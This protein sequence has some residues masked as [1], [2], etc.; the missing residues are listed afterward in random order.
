MADETLGFYGARRLD[1][2]WHRAGGRGSCGS[3]APG[4]AT[5]GLRRWRASLEAIRC[6]VWRP[7]GGSLP[8]KDLVTI[9]IWVLVLILTR[10]VAAWLSL[11]RPL[12]FFEQTMPAWPP[13][14]PF[15]L[16]LERVLVAPWA[17]WDAHW[18]AR[19]VAQGY[20]AG[21]GTT[22]FYPLYPL[23]AMPL[24]WLGLSPIVALMLVSLGASLGVILMFE[25]MA[26]WEMNSIRAREVTLAFMLFPVAFVLSAPYAEALFLLWAI[27]SVSAARQGRWGRAGLAAALAAL[28]RPQGLFLLLPLGALLWRTRS[29]IRPFGSL[30]LPILALAGWSVYRITVIEGF[31]LPG[32]GLNVYVY[33]LL[34]SPHANQVVPSQAFLW[35][36]EALGRALGKFL[37]GPDVDLTVN[38]VLAA[39]FL[40]LTARA[41]RWMN[42]GERLYTMAVVMS[43]FSYHTGPVHPYM[44]LPRHLW[45]AFPVFLAF[46]RSRS[47]LTRVIPAVQIPAFFFMIILYVLEAWVP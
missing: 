22:Q 14:A 6:R 19:I 25:R 28:T 18:Y 4:R 43:A 10:L 7:P 13:T 3:G 40:V 45:I 37:Q 47:A 20:Q 39:W 31:H 38:L 27:V 9:A 1:C 41:W 33:S 2:S 36:W 16:W 23:L 8:W 29:T 32:K 11:L 15:S 17:R 34:L 30:F 24:A 44:G 21:D 46:G 26:R 5:A 12:T 42:P 35:P